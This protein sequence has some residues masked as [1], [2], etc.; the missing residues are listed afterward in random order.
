MLVE[1]VMGAIYTAGVIDKVSLVC[2]PKYRATASAA[3]W[4]VANV[5]RFSS[6]SAPHFLR[7]RL[8]ACVAGILPTYGRATLFVLYT[9]L[10]AAR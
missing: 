1:H 5:P 4:G 7:F 6:P 10:R 2:C 8:L 9:N 3:S